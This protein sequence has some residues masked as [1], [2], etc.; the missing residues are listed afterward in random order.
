MVKKGNM[1]KEDSGTTWIQPMSP[2][3]STYSVDRPFDFFPVKHEVLSFYVKTFN[4]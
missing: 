4:L 2:C 1:S 3:G